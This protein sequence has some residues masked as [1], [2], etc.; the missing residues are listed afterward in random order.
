[1]APAAKPAMMR[2]ARAMPWPST[3]VSGTWAGAMPRGAL[4]PG[5]KKAPGESAS[6]RVFLQI[7]CR[8]AGSG[9]RFRT[10]ANRYP[11]QAT[12][13]LGPPQNQTGR[14]IIVPEKRPGPA[15]P[16]AED[17]P[18]CLPAPARDVSC[19]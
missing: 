8:V 11:P 19:K 5:F 15:R 13:M 16:C 6:P 3:Q 12:V 1:M 7:A 4:R 18:D 17:A 14:W 10:N 2:I 9:R